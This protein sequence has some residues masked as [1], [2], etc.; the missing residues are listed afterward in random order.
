MSQPG[1]GNLLHDASAQQVKKAVLLVRDPHVPRG[2]AGNRIHLPGG[3][4][5]YGNI[6]VILQVAG[7]AK[8][9]HPDSSAIILKKGSQSLIR[10]S[11]ASQLTH[12][13]TRSG[14]HRRAIAT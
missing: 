6:P 5:A 7:A 12:G 4:A 3:N 9:G 2:V 10:Q 11:A 8:R 1:P 14:G 13:S